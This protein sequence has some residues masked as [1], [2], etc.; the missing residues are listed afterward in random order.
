[1]FRNRLLIVLVL[2]LV[3]IRF[4]IAGWHEMTVNSS[5][6]DGDQGAYLQLG[7]ELKSDGALTDG[8]RNPLYPAVL[9][10]FARRDWS[11][12]TLAKYASLAFGVL[13][14]I[15]LFVAA[16]RLFNWKTALLA[17]MLLGINVN[18]IQHSAMALGESLLILVFFL[19]WALSVLALRRNKLTCWALAG[20]LTGLAHLTKGTGQLIVGA[21]VVSAV[22]LKGIGILKSRQL[23]TY[24][25]IYGV[26]VL[27]LWGYNLV[28][29]GSPNFNYATTHQMWMD[30]WRDWYNT[31]RTELPTALTFVRDHSIGEIVQREWEGIEDLRFILAKT[32]FP[33]KSLGFDKFLLSPWSTGLLVVVALLILAR[34]RQ[35]R[36]YWRRH[37]PELT[38][39]CALFVLFY[40]LFAWYTKIVPRGIRFLLPLLPILL[41]VLSDVVVESVSSMFR[42]LRCRP[43][44][45]VLAGVLCCGLVYSFG[46]VPQSTWAM[47]DALAQSVFQLDAK[48]N[49]FSDYPLRWL[50]EVAPRGAVVVQAYTHS[51]PTW[52]YSDW[53]VFAPPPDELNMTEFGTFLKEQQADYVLVESVLLKYQHAG[54]G[55]YFGQAEGKMIE[56]RGCPPGW[57]LALAYPGLP[58]RWAVFRVL[59]QSEMK[60]GARY[61]LGGHTLLSGYELSGERVQAGQTLRLFIHW[62]FL[63]PSAQDLTVFTQLLGPDSQLHGQKDNPPL[64]GLVHTSQPPVLNDVVDRYDITVP[65]DAP[66][67]TYQVLVGMYDPSTGERVVAYRGDEPLPSNAIPLATVVVTQ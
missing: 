56:L 67:G 63:R 33:R 15:V 64:E 14:V 62:N 5:S 43:S 59:D 51:L 65:E 61:A 23:W 45:Y 7:L 19:A 11:Y 27:P 40:L 57:G 55:E 6:Q 32:L 46:W 20:L 17:S 2:L 47:R 35:A 42:R 18:L 29:F 26:V 36:A 49:S 28:H 21:V 16:R 48:F 8:V 10:P 31:E 24:L 54:L 53:F 39:T 9:S 66:P 58:F 12:F 52:R 41:V 4:V 3:T 30:Q 22:L 25:G 50:K 13:S 37:R 38:V 44:R 60:T 1:M 34:R